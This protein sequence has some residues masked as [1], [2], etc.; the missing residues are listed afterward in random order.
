M[1]VKRRRL[2]RGWTQ[3]EMAARAGLRTPTYVLFER[4]GQVSLER[5]IKVFEVLDLAS[6][7]ERLGTGEDL[8]GATLDQ[9]VEPERQR[10]RRPRRAP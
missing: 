3:Q 4:T 6:E 7:I 9:L 10:G 8:A 5:L 1:R 2:R